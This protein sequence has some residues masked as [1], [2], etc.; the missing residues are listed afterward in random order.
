MNKNNDIIPFRK[1]L[2]ED[3]LWGLGATL[4][5]IMIPINLIS[6]LR[7]I[8]FLLL[9]SLIC[10]SGWILVDNNI[11]NAL[12]IKALKIFSFIGK[13]QFFYFFT[14]L[15]FAFAKFRNNFFEFWILLMFFSLAI[16]VSSYAFILY[17]TR[18]ISLDKKISV[19]KYLVYI[20]IISILY[21]LY[22]LLSSYV[23]YIYNSN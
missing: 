1:Y 17:L 6:P 20:L 9:T 18:R 19:K 13:F 16:P 3:L 12:R 7:I 23:D 14:I 8:E 21:L 2:E 11:I 5:F 22:H 15:L 4:L 10:I